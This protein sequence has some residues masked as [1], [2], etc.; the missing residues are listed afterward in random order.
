MDNNIQPQG[1][2]F[3]I[4]TVKCPNCM[5]PAEYEAYSTTKG[6]HN[7]TTFVDGSATLVGK[8]K[9]DNVKQEER[10]AFRE[11]INEEYDL[12]DS[13][14]YHLMMDIDDYVNQQV[15]QALEEA[16]ETKK[17]HNLKCDSREY[18]YIDSSVIN[19]LIKEYKVDKG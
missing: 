19:G 8:P 17:L 9:P 5:T 7:A 11:K 14:A 3:H 12:G 4:N 10:L 1:A 18:F 6:S 2:C 13:T 16:L 15:V